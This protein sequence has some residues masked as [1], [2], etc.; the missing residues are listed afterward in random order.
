MDVNS[1]ESKYIWM[2]S[3]L[4]PREGKGL[5]VTN[6]ECLIEIMTDST[7]TFSWNEF[8]DFAL[9]VSNVNFYQSVMMLSG[10]IACFHYPY[11]MQIAGRFKLMGL[12]R[13]THTTFINRAKIKKTKFE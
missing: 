2:G 9:P 3:Y 4:C 12:R 5:F 6:T 1:D 11:S 13:Q 8:L 7:V 10:T